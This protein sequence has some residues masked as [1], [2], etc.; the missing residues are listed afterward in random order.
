MQMHFATIWEAIADAI[1][2][3][4]AL[5][6]GDERRSWGEFDDRAARVARALQQSGVGPNS[7]VAQYLYNGTEYLEI[8]F[9]A[10]KQGAVP[11]NTNWRYLEDELVY[12]LDNADA[13]VLFFHG[14][15]GERVAKVLPDSRS[16]GRS[17]RST[18]ARPGFP[19]PSTTRS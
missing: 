10:F 6:H 19:A 12:L 15:L 13:E 7:K 8:C 2:D 3:R 14:A 4:A 9:A 18:T 5:V 16:C 1:P 11:I 17:S